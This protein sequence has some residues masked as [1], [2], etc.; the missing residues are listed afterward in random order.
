ME[1]KVATSEE[2]LPAKANEAL[3]QIKQMDYLAEFR[4]QNI[5]EV[6]QYGIAFCGK[7]CQVAT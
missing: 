7:K 2:E 3:A 4:Q 6:W 5:N 1:F